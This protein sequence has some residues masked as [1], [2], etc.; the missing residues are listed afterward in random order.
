MERQPTYQP[1]DPQI[2]DQSVTL[3]EMRTVQLSDGIVGTALE[4]SDTPYED[5]VQ[6]PWYYMV[7]V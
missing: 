1:F 2:H 4:L 5:A 6:T 3:Y 7:R